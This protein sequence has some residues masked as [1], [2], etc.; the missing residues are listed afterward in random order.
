MEPRDASG[1]DIFEISGFK[2]HIRSSV[3]LARSEGAPTEV[4]SEIYVFYMGSQFNFKRKPRS[5]VAL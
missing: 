1:S 2:S 5:S 3:T 4:P